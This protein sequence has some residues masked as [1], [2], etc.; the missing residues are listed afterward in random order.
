MQPDLHALGIGL[1][2]IVATLVGIVAVA[3]VFFGAR[4]D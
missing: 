2:V 3:L 1:L 4:R